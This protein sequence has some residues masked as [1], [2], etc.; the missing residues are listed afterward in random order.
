MHISA[1][2]HIEGKPVLR[3]ARGEEAHW[4]EIRDSMDW[5]SSVAVVFARAVPPEVLERAVAAFNEVIAQGEIKQAA[6]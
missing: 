5:H 3:F 6:E 4:V 2:I 1:D